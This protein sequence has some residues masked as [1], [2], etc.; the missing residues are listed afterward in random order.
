MPSLFRQLNSLFNRRERGQLTI[1]AIA[2]VVRAGVEMV[3]VGSIAPFMSVVADPS[4]MQS[5]AWLRG[6]Y[7]MFGFTSSTAF[8]TALGVAV[9]VVLAV[10]NTFSALALWGML[11]FSYGMHHRLSNRLLRGYLAQPYSFF[12]ERNSA[13]FSKTILTEVMQVIQGV[14]TPV[15]NITARSLVVVALVGLLIV[16][17]PMLAVVIVIVLSGAYGGLYVLVRVKQ[18]RLGRERVAANQERFKVTGEAFGGIKDVKVLGREDAFA[19]RFAPASWTFSKATASNAVIAQLPRYLFE[20]IAFSG[21]V[22]IVLYYLQAGEGLAQ[23][24]PTISLYAFAGY[25]LMPE[26]QQ[27]FGGVAAIRFNRAALDDLTDDLNRFVPVAETG[28]AEAVPF[29]E[30]IHFEGVTFRYPGTD[31]PALGGITLTI[32]RNQTIGLVGASG[33]G[34]T[35]LVDLLLGLYTPESGR[36]FVDDTPLTPTMLGA[37][38]RQVGYVPQHIF[39]CDDTIANNIAFGV[40]EADVDQAS[41]ERA[42][43]VA[44]LHEFIGTLPEGYRT[45][46]GERGVR[47]S[48]GQRQRIGIARALYHDPEVLVM[49]EA[50]SALDGATEGAVMEAIQELSGRKTLVL[51][52][53]RLSTVKD[54]D[55]IYLLGQGKVIDQGKFE[56]LMI[57][58]KAFRAMANL[59]PTHIQSAT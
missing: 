24:L 36:L 7:E 54:A 2:L 9:I 59:A 22:M 38:R 20:T 43:R 30:A 41:V 32:P 39:L 17:D 42:A 53:H 6:A 1:L 12:V 19:A 5:N 51:I 29:R 49:D 55:C 10:A 18:R 58:S 35:T 34:K 15:L 47:L 14:M 28:K 25:R 11:R 40:P 37:W 52:A 4:V 23:I 31:Q 44:H 21:I 57:N 8:L 13:S 46:V 26:L 50:T 33:S 27:L 48:G 3:G 45:V 16:L 56:T